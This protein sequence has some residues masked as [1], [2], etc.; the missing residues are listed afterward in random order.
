MQLEQLT[1][2]EF[3]RRLG[4]SFV[5]HRADGGNL[6]LVLAEAQATSSVRGPGS[7]GAPGRLPFSLLFS[8]P[9]EPRLAQGIHTLTMPGETGT[10][11]LFL[12][13]IGPYAGG[14][15]YEAVFT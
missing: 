15:G 10:L 7:G 14:M 11:D 2:T 6:V 3:E 1:V 13:P 4:Q 9:A 5:L 8:G 12:V